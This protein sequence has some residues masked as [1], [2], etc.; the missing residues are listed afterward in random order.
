MIARAMKSA[1]LGISVYH[2]FVAS[3]GSA[4]IP[5]DLAIAFNSGCGSEKTQSWLP[6][7][8]LLVEKKVT[9]V[10]TVC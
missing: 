1:D 2:D 7:V 9:S 10:F 8:R 6:T 3:Q 4:Y 5:P